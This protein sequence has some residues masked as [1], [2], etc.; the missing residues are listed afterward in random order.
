MKGGNVNLQIG[1]EQV[2]LVKNTTGV[3]LTDGQ[4]V[5]ITGASGNRPTIALADADSEATS[6]KTF[7]IVTEPMAI[8]AEGFITTSGLVRGL[9]TSAFSE[10]VAVW[11]SST[12]GAFTA[13]KPAA[14]AHGVMIGWV[15]RSHATV[16][17]I[18][19]HVQNGY[20]LDELHDMLITAKANSDSIMYDSAS[21]LW[22][23]IPPASARTRL[24]VYSTTE[25]QTMAVN[26]AIAMA[27][28]LG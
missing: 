19:V 14:P 1:Q 13:T 25:A 28:A 8:D 17:V 9:N 15:V 23:N 27:I 2:V 4:V 20:E 7:G 16:G 18:L 5:Y 12:A 21:G 24:D 22:K 10:G 26:N 11:L 6:S 3:A